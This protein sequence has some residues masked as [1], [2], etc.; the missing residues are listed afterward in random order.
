[1]VVAHEPADAA[2]EAELPQQRLTTRR[3]TL[4][5]LELLLVERARL[6]QDLVGN[7]ELADVVQEAA[8]RQLAQARCGDAEL[9]PHLDREQRDAAGVTL[10]V[11]VL[12]GQEARQ[13]ADLRAEVGLFRRDELGAAEVARERPGRRGAIEVCSDRTLRRASTPATSSPWPSHQARSR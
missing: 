11:L 1:M 2:A 9:L 5:E 4:D 3:M 13:R 6:L 10:G 12:R 8:D 7:G